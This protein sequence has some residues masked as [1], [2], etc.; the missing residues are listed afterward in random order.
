[1][2]GVVFNSRE[3]LCWIMTLFVCI[4]P[5]QYTNSCH[6][7]F[8]GLCYLISKL[9]KTIGLFW[10]PSQLPQNCFKAEIQHDF[11]VHLFVFFVFL[12]SG[13]IVLGASCSRFENCCFMYLSSFP[14][15]DPGKS[16]LDSLSPSKSDRILLGCMF[17]FHF[18]RCIVQLFSAVTS[19]LGMFKNFFIP[20]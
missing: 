12:L 19:H 5:L 16:S 20:H 14:C 17:I 18:T 8:A 11:R 1:M 6:F 13:I 2:W 10:F 9:I 15:A 3:F 4:S 7:S